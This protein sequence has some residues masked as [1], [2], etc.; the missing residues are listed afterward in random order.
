M[1]VTPNLQP[2]AASR[3]DR[4]ARLHGLKV[5]SPHHG[6]DKQAQGP[7]IEQHRFVP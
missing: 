4:G 1:G 2:L 3:S 6:R 5:R 7:K